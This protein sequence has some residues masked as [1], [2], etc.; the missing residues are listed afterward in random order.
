[1]GLGLCGVVPVG[2]GGGG[3][4]T[5]EFRGVIL[6]RLVSDVVLPSLEEADATADALRSALGALADAPSIETIRAAQEAWRDARWTW[7]RAEAV[8]IG[9]AEDR[10]LATKVDT[11]PVDE[12]RIEELVA[13]AEVLDVQLVRTLGSTRK[14]FHAIE[15][16]L[17]APDDDVE[18]DVSDVLESLTTDPLAARRL[19]LLRA[20]GED[21]ADVVG[22][23]RMSW[24]PSGEDHA[25]TFA[26]AGEPGSEYATRQEAIDDLLNH[27][28]TLTELIADRRLGRP[29]GRTSG[30]L[31]QEPGAESQR[32]ANSKRD[33][34]ADLLG[35][36]DA[37]EGSRDG[38]PGAGLSSLIRRGYPEIHAAVRGDI[39]V[40]IALVDAI[41]ETLIGTA[42]L[43]PEFV[44][45]AFQAVRQVRVRLATDATAALSGTLKFSPYDGD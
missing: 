15:L 31:P 16:L 1:V 19:D 20:W 25:G 5:D 10:L 23:A 33:V 8:L 12:V 37:Y 7:N 34:L 26:G 44:E 27:L 38:E 45:A 21:V 29:L 28:I 6:S 30:G 9:P 41:P 3:Q 2:C 4:S 32:S 35:L 13:G 24:D 11:S 36:R 18:D 14:G 39:D 40:A 17:F 43:E 42:G 22:E